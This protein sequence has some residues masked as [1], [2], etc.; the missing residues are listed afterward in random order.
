MISNEDNW[1]DFPG[2]AEKPLRWIENP[3][4]V[5]LIRFVLASN[6]AWEIRLNDF[7]EEPMYTLIVEGKEVLNFTEWPDKWAKASL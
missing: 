4:D 3:T 1:N 6:S 2:L 7:P 5:R